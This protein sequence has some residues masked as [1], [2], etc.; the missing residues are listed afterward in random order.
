MNHSQIHELDPIVALSPLVVNNDTEGKGATID[1]R[2]AEACLLVAHVGASGDTLASGTSLALK[3]QHADTDADGSDPEDGDFTDVTD[4]Q[5]L[6]L[7]PSRG[8]TLDEATGVFRT[9]DDPAEDDVT[10]K[11]AYLGDKPFVRL[12]VDTTGTHT[13][14]TPIAAFAILGRLRRS[15]GG[16]TPV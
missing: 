2:G 10:V 8:D 15:V 14:G 4:P 3:V 9:I 11:V 5:H 1:T 16:A 6:V 13:N 7:D 12:V